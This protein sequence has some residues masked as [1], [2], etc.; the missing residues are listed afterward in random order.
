MGMVCFSISSQN[1]FYSSGVPDVPGRM[2][3]F[4]S[5]AVS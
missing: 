5:V 4:Y 3:D 1:L 2:A